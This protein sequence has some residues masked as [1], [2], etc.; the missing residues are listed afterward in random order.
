[1]QVNTIVIVYGVMLGDLWLCLSSPP[2]I[3]CAAVML[4]D[5]HTTAR[6]LG[7]QPGVAEDE[8]VPAK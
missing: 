5:Y 6:V 8:P 2:S 4:W 1:M 7:T 3:V